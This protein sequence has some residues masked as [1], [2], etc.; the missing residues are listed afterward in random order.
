MSQP[1][2]NKP[3]KRDR[4]MYQGIV[5][6]CLGGENFK[7]QLD[8]DAGNML[9]MAKLKGKIRQRKHYLRVLL[10]D[11]VVVEVSPYEPTKGVIARLIKNNK[12]VELDE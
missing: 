5:V 3:C 11:T 6:D 9:V 2:K 4:M 7:V 8:Q 10:G 12:P 1:E